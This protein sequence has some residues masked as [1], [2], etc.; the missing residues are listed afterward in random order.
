MLF[1]SIFLSSSCLHQSND[2]RVVGR[3]EQECT[4]QEKGDIIG[5]YPQAIAR[6]K[7]SSLEY[8]PKSLD[9]QRPIRAKLVITSLNLL[10]NMFYLLLYFTYLFFH[11]SYFYI[12]KSMSL[13]VLAWLLS[14]RVMIK[15]H[16]CRRRL[17]VSRGRHGLKVLRNVYMS[18]SCG[19][20]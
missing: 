16:F 7:P 6:P 2:F 12:S 13:S 3:S 4:L 19:I 9:C 10:Y 18:P 14:C 8:E 20:I 5:L 17:L 11:H 1:G 15:E